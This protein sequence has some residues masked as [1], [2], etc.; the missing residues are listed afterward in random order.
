MGDPRFQKC[1]AIPAGTACIFVNDWIGGVQARQIGAAFGRN[2]LFALEAKFPSEK[3]EIV[4]A[5]LLQRY[6]SPCEERTENPMN[7]FG[8]RFERRIRVWCFS[9]GKATFLSMTDKA[10]EGAFEFAVSDATKEAAV[11]DF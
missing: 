8:H 9:D 2:G 7:I 3:A 11:Q 5:A 4:E 10:S 6:G 1:E